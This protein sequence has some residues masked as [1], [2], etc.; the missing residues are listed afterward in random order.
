MP[1]TITP[2][3][4]SEILAKGG[5]PKLLDVRTPAEFAECH[6][7]GAKL[8]PLD[9]LDPRKA[10]AA[11]LPTGKTPIFLLCKG[12]ARAAKA[13]ERFFAAGIGDVCVVIGGTDAC[14]SAGVPVVRRAGGGKMLPIDGQVRIVLGTMILSFWL[15][16]RFVHPGFGWL[17]L[18]MAGGL[19]F[20][21]MTGFC[22]TSI[23]LGKAPWNRHP[24]ADACRVC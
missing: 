23:L 24:E 5:S 8:A 6:V 4:L 3:Q 14:V 9:V 15:L 7:Q 22:G 11:L 10:A 17:V 16:E 12:G 20:S 13:A 19:I 18:F 21:G 1:S 2:A